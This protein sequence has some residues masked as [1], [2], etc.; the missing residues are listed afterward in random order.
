MTRGFLL[1]AA[2]AAASAAAPLGAQTRPAPTLDEVAD[3]IDAGA[4][5]AAD[6]S[7]G[8]WRQG[9]PSASESDR[10]R[11]Q[12]LAARLQDDGTAAQH[13]YLAL[14]LAHPF[15]PDAALALLRVGQ[16]ALLQ[17][18][19]AAATT[20]LRRLI[21]DFPDHGQR[22]EA[23]LWLSRAHGLAGRG[24]IACETARAGLALGASPEVSELLRVQESRAC[25]ARAAAPPDPRAPTAAVPVG[26]RFAVQTGAFRGRAGADALSERLRREGHQPRLARVP[27]ND[28]M[29]VRVGSFVDEADAERLR[30]R[31]RAAG[32]DAVVVE[33]VAR[34][35][36]VD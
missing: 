15:S 21:D 4:L 5:A 23:H 18:D 10:A 14:A 28:L 8:V 19:T 24:G 3:L 34:E 16:A 12:L 11:A 1:V 25:S 30:D 27:A 17:G 36:P 31:L 26:A 13:A 2:V 7:L 35:T 29:R 33:D 20:Y 6:S 9:A 22:A 32:F